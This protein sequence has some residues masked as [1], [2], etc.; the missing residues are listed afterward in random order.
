MNTY[1]P[2]TGT[3]PASRRGPCVAQYASKEGDVKVFVNETAH[4]LEATVRIQDG[5]KVS[6]LNHL[7]DRRTKSNGELAVAVKDKKGNQLVFGTQ[8]IEK[9]ERAESEDAYASRRALLFV[10]D[11]SAGQRAYAV[12]P[13]R[14]VNL[15]FV[16]PTPRTAAPAAPV[17]GEP[18][19]E[20]A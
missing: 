10:Y 4:G 19:I 16:Q 15:D 11:R 13:G 20:M 1:A 6:F 8:R 7:F 3:T 2:I 17:V 9:G 14:I 5:D 18:A 12:L